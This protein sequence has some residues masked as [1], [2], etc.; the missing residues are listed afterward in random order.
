MM[1]H[2]GRDPR[3]SHQSSELDRFARK[4]HG[5]SIGLCSGRECNSSGFPDLSSPG[6][7]QPSRRCITDISF[8]RS[9]LGNWGY[10]REQ[11]NRRRRAERLMP[12]DGPWQLTRIVRD[13]CD[14]GL[15]LDVVAI[16]EPHVGGWL[17]TGREKKRKFPVGWVGG[18]EIGPR[19]GGGG[20]NKKNKSRWTTGWTMNDER[21]NETSRLPGPDAGPCTLNRSPPLSHSGPELGRG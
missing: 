4:D 5:F 10:A 2:G 19:G 13:A 1:D 16:S 21:K 15:T 12:L 20:G 6:E 14:G 17:S 18:K 11:S 3:S 9:G 7:S 8:V